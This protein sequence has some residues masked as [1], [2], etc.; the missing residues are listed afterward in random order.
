MEEIDH[1]EVKT[2]SD[3]VRINYVL[4]DCDNGIRVP[5]KDEKVSYGKV[6]TSHKNPVY[7]LQK[8]VERIGEL[9]LPRQKS[10]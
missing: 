10:R 7:S 2:I 4:P 6:K 8:I 3:V 9:D 1:L 5:S